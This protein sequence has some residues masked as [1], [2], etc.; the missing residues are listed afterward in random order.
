M[1]MRFKSAM[2]PPGGLPVFLKTRST[3]RRHDERE[4]RLQLVDF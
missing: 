3:R 1:Q 2:V 4:H